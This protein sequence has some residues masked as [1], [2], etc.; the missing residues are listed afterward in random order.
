M[1]DGINDQ[2]QGMIEGG[3]KGE[4]ALMPTRAAVLPSTRSGA[5]QTVSKLTMLLIEL[6]MFW[7]P[8]DNKTAR[9]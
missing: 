8:G 9:S 4:N 1:R 5:E 3:E 2:V 6:L 7:A